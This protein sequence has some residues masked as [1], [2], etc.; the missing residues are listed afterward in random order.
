MID[1]SYL[2]Y[3]SAREYL[4]RGMAKWMGFFLSEH[5]TALSAGGDSVDFSAGEGDEMKMLCLAQVFLQ[6]RDI[7]LYTTVQ[8]E[9]LLGRVSY[10][11]EEKLYFKTQGRIPNFSYAQIRGL[12]LAEEEDRGEPA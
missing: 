1:R 2:P 8:K 7:L 12:T 6:K 10:M 5:N 9:P 4:D 11:A 3:A